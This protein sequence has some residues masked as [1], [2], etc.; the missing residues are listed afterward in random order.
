MKKGRAHELPLSDP[1][2]EL[3]RRQPRLGELIFPDPATNKHYTHF[4]VMHTY[5]QR[6]FSL[7]HGKASSIVYPYTPHGMR[8][9]FK[10]WVQHRKRFFEPDVVEMCLSH[11]VGNKVERAYAED[12]VPDKMRQVLDAWA[13]YLS[14]VPVPKVVSLQR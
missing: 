13:D 12:S 6:G 9:S 5:L 4:S 2:I 7:R 11:L 3:L 8:R 10:T 1:A 14:A